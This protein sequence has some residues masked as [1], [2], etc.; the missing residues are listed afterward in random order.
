LLGE[1]AVKVAMACRNKPWLWTGGNP[2]SL[3]V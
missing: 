1:V 2:L 3:F